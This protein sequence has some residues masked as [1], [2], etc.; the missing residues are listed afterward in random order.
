[1]ILQLCY[2]IQTI[3]PVV[4]LV[5]SIYLWPN[6]PVQL[7]QQ[8][9]K[10]VNKNLGIHRIWA[11]VCHFQPCLLGTTF[12]GVVKA[13]LWCYSCGTDQSGGNC[14]YRTHARHHQTV[15]NYQGRRHTA[16]HDV[17]VT[18][19][20]S[21][22]DE[23]HV[24]FSI[25]VIRRLTYMTNVHFQDSTSIP[26]R[27]SGQVHIESVC[28]Q[29]VCLGSVQAVCTESAVGRCQSSAQVNIQSL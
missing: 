15:G 28:G 8:Q 23:S 22:I 29:L 1:M 9:S 4:S 25:R 14:G 24:V 21:L 2:R 27:T 12:Y 18:F 3:K 17:S 6:D 10:N 19:S 5:K 16:Y 11:V 26:D 13:F 7:C 20:L